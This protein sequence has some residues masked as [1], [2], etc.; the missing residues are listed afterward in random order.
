MENS[1]AKAKLKKIVIN[2]G[3]KEALT[4]KKVL[5]SMALQLAQITGQKPVITSARRAI[6]EF[7]LREGDKIGL[8]ITL[9]R[10]RMFDFLQK[11]VS[12][13]LPRVRDFKGIPLSGFDGQGNY[14]LGLAEIM[15]FPE[16]DFAKIDKQSFSSN[17]ARGLEITIV[18]TAK[19]NEK[20][21]KLLREMGMP[22]SK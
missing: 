1:L 6:A 14:T 22:F 13:V 3:L 20:A 17:K 11:L 21:E 19:N 9:R 18:T 8:K 7:K 16:V 4:D 12:I 2:V 10:S 15:V 5:D